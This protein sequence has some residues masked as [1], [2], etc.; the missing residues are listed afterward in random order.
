MFITVFTRTSHW[1][2]SET[3]EPRTN[4]QSYYLRFVLIISFYLRLHLRNGLFTSG[5]PNICMHF[6]SSL[7]VLHVHLILDLNTVMTPGDKYEMWI[8][9]LYNISN[10]RVTS[11]LVSATVPTPFFSDSHD[12]GLCSSLK[13]RHRVSQFHNHKCNRVVVLY[14]SVV[15]YLSRKR[16]DRK[17]LTRWKQ[18]FPHFNLL[19]TSSWICI[20]LHMN[21][22]TFFMELVPRF[23]FLISPLKAK[24]IWIIFKN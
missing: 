22:V 12:T 8:S 9:P 14:T 10:A 13:V 15:R 18:A 7:C 11:S 16:K 2:H 21:S 1:T 17:F 20:I 23:Y 6:T 19:S 3:Y 4:S 24:F 5:F